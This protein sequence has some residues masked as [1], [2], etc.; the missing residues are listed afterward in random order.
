MYT[1]S[2]ALG[3]VYYLDEKQFGLANQGLAEV[4]SEHSGQNL[5]LHMFVRAVEYTLI[6]VAEQ[7]THQGG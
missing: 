2:V 3:Q 1:V 6:T 5:Q 7:H 4:S